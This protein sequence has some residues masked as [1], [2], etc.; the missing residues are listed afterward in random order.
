[1][2]VSILAMLLLTPCVTRKGLP[3]RDRLICADMRF[4]V[5][6]EP[7]ENCVLQLQASRLSDHVRTH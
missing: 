2:R 7:Y 6:S 3:Q 5:R 4:A 1:M